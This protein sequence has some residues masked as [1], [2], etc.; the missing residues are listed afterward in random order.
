MLD[1]DD[2]ASV[3]DL[4]NRYGGID[5]T[6]G[7]AKDYVERGKSSLDVFVDSPGKQA[8]LGLADYVVTRKR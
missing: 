4:V 6:I 1:K 2:F 7:R 3:S 5:Y 8:M